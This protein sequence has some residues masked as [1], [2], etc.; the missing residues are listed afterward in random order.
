MVEGSGSEREYFERALETPSVVYEILE[1]G[2]VRERLKKRVEV[3]VERVFVRKVNVLVFLDRSARPL[4]WL[5][6]SIW[7]RR[8]PNVPPPE[9]RF[10]NVGTTTLMNGRKS[11]PKPPFLENEK[12]FRARIV[13]SETEDE[14]LQ[15]SEIPGSWDEY[16]KFD[17]KAQQSVSELFSKQFDG[18]HVLIVDDFVNSGNTLSRALRMFSEALPPTSHCEGTALFLANGLQA[19]KKVLPWLHRDGIAGIL[20]SSDPDALLSLPL[21]ERGM[22]VVRSELRKQITELETEEKVKAREAIELVH[23]IVRTLEQVKSPGQ[24]I[25]VELMELLVCLQQHLNTLLENGTSAQIERSIPRILANIFRQLLE[26]RKNRNEDM[27]PVIRLLEQWSVLWEPLRFAEQVRER[28]R[29]L[30]THSDIPEMIRCSKQLRKEMAQLAAEPFVSNE[31][32]NK[33]SPKGDREESY[34]RIGPRE[35]GS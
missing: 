13:A 5:V 34:R 11:V 9:I 16:F 30:D 3:F 26:L 10:V 35:R 8:Y 25:Q 14:W 19:D 28:K 24:A 1:S 20:E 15:P 22:E 29:L 12:R 7:K 27:N 33:K 6:R 21:N 17:A 31:K 32:C 23:E 2:V 4:A 18:A